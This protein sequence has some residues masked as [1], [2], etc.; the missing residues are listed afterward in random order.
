MFSRALKL[1]LLSLVFLSCS[2]E[3]NTQV[4]TTKS[5]ERYT[6]GIHYEVIEDPTTVREPSKVEVI[7]VFWFGC[8]HCYALEPYLARWKKD[9]PEGVN[10]S[11]SPATWNEILRTHARMYYTA[12]ALGIEQQF[13]PA[14]FNTIQNEGRRL[15]G[16]TELEYFFKGFDID[17]EKYKSVSNSF[18]VS[19]A[20]DQADK[21]MKQ[22]EI[23]GVPVI[24][25]NGKYRVGAS[26]S[27]GTD[28]L[29]DVVNFLVEKEKKYSATN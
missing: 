28:G 12:K 5:N 22:W 6:E 16:N 2:S 17:R 18:G 11:K 24:I 8:N 23:T 13:I 7:E 26:R 20:V 9:M 27:V 14:A 29:F 21:K 3:S 25:V 15:T 1:S 19:N 10:F 4:E